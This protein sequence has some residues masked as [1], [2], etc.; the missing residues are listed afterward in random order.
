MLTVVHVDG[1]ERQRRRAQLLEAMRADMT[2]RCV[3]RI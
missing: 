3:E 2:H 1:L